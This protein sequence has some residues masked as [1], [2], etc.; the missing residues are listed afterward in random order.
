MS[1]S[2]SK[3]NLIPRLTPCAALC[4]PFISKVPPVYPP[5]DRLIQAKSNPLNAQKT[6]FFRLKYLQNISWNADM[7]W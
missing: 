1:Q 5:R 4:W 3:A 2:E 7:T 6:P